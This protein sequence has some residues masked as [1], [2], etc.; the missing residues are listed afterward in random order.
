[1]NPKKKKLFK[2]IHHFKKRRDGNRTC[3]SADQLLKTIDG[4]IWAENIPDGG[5]KFSFSL[6]DIIKMNKA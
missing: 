5:A 4:K 1:M 6:E 2:T 3:Q